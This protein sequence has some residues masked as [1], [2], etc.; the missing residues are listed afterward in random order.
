MT[1]YLDLITLRCSRDRNNLRSIDETFNSYARMTAG[2]VA[3]PGVFGQQALNKFRAAPTI[4][5][6]ISVRSS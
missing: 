5:D 1:I 3:K 4:L 2:A 6:L